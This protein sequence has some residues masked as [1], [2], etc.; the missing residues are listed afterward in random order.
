MVEE[1]DYVS[2][3]VITRAIWAPWCSWAL[4]RLASEEARA[5]LRQ[6]FKQTAESR[7]C[8]AERYGIAD[9]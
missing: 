1:L 5:A 2:V 8:V 4:S 3:I 6:L 9:R 7:H